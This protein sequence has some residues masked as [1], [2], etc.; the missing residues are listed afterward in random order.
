MF[1]CVTEKES[2]LLEFLRP[3]NMGPGTMPHFRN[4]PPALRQAER[5]TM[6]KHLTQYPGVGKFWTTRLESLRNQNPQTRKRWDSVIATCVHRQLFNSL[7]VWPQQ[8]SPF[9]C[10]GPFSVEWRRVFPHFPGLR[11]ADSK[12]TTPPPPSPHAPFASLTSRSDGMPQ[13]GPKREKK[14]ITA[15]T[16]V[17]RGWERVE[18]M[19]NSLNRHRPGR[20]R[21]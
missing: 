13:R 20:D 18:V 19:R 14:W 9:V 8:T 15:E 12:N 4:S 10:L 7:V 1:S 2:S 11:A 17:E 21:C 3:R 16:E 5:Q 6:F